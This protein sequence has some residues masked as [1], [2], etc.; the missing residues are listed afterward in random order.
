MSQTAAYG[1]DLRMAKEEWFAIST[2]ISK[3]NYTIGASTAELAKLANVTN[4]IGG[5]FSEVSGYLIDIVGK[6]SL[7]GEEVTDVA[8]E[9][10]R[11][12]LLYGRGGALAKESLATVTKMSDRLK[13]AGGNA[14]E[15][16]T[17]IAGA[18]A[19]FTSAAGLGFLPGFANTNVGLARYNNMLGGF[20]K[21]I[22][23]QSAV[24]RGTLADAF[25][26]LFNLSGDAMLQF[27]VDATKTLN[28]TEIEAR[29]V[30]K[31][32]KEMTQS[33]GESWTRL[34][35]RIFKSLQGGTKPILDTLNS[36]T[37]K[38][39][40]IFD[41]GMGDRLTKLVGSVGGGIIEWVDDFVKNFDTRMTEFKGYLNAVLHPIDTLWNTLKGCF[42]LDTVKNVGA[43]ATLMW[44][45]SA[46]L[47]GTALSMGWLV[48]PLASTLT[49]L[50]G[51]TVGLAA[52]ALAAAAV[53][54]AGWGLAK[55][56][57]ALGTGISKIV[58]ALG[59]AFKDI[60]EGASTVVDS[61]GNAWAKVISAL[62]DAAVQLIE[63]V[64]SSVE[65]LA[66]VD[67]YRLGIVGSGLVDLSKGLLAFA[68]AGIV[69]ALSNV[70][71]FLTT[72]GGGLPGMFEKFAGMGGGLKSAGEGIN[73]LAAG[74]KA[75]PSKF[76]FNF[77]EASFQSARRLRDA[78]TVIDGGSF[79]L[80]RVVSLFERLDLVLRS[81]SIAKEFRL[82]S[83]TEAASLLY[84]QAGTTVRALTAVAA[85]P[86]S[87]SSNA[88]P[89]SPARTSVNA[90]AASTNVFAGVVEAIERQTKLMEEQAAADKARATQQLEANQS[91]NNTVG[92]GAV[93][94]T[95]ATTTPR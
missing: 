18:N 17:A 82:P 74:I 3:V 21:M 23:S 12:N 84:K 67:G 86:T 9:L 47:R 48:T 19:R 45:L 76:S 25:G 93:R 2:T 10:S 49:V 81:L 11:M 15:L 8:H 63:Q 68:G 44:G 28:Q 54:V 62:K 4:L 65:R 55:L 14:K 94:R 46:A 64:A 16:V 69:Q 77:D 35:N 50:T 52:F 78:V 58:G 30:N 79:A 66:I 60:L 59:G 43:F 32:W 6:T 92:Q 87:V 71:S 29:D 90:P 42:S 57:E 31:V 27:G 40:K 83:I 7:T 75:M 36:L 26:P 89:V 13:Q 39:S 20:S 37:E 56:F 61:F 85:P 24:V 70:A 88:S 33:M 1:F 53:G 80:Q 91:N 5:N 38:I 41:D 72:G 95:P 34:W 73:A 51:G 22:M